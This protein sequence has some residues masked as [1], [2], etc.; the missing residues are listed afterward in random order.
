MA[1]VPTSVESDPEYL[2]STDTEPTSQKTRA[3]VV[4][5]PNASQDPTLLQ[6][7]GYATR[8]PSPGQTESC[9]EGERNTS[10]LQKAI[11]FPLAKRK[12]LL[13][14]KKEVD[15]GIIARFNEVIPEIER[16]LLSHIRSNRFFSSST[17]H[18]PMAIRLMVLG[19]TESDAEECMV[20]FCS[21]DLL[22]RVEQFFKKDPIVRDLCTPRDN[23]VP[24]FKVIVNAQPP[25]P[26]ATF[27]DI[28]VHCASSLSTDDTFCGTPIKFVNNTEE[29]RIATFCGIIKVTSS[30]GV[31]KLYGMTAGH[32]LL[33]WEY[34][35]TETDHFVSGST[36][37]TSLDGENE[38]GVERPG[39][40]VEDLME[41]GDSFVQVSAIPLHTEQ[42]ETAEAWLF[43]ESQ[44][45]GRVLQTSNCEAGVEDEGKQYFDWALFEL[46]TYRQNEL[47]MAELS[48][49]VRK[50]QLSLA[51]EKLSPDSPS[52]LV[53]VMG[54]SQG[55][56]RGVLSKL[57]G[58][59]IMGPGDA[60]INAYLLTLD[61]GQS[62][63]ISTLD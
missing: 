46:N 21:A 35:E 18:K 43:P 39:D 12:E 5:E 8:W 19:K 24:S 56:K 2:Q 50:H 1:V 54:G 30:N 37:H 58:R 40:S 62:K 22:K 60:F 33:D 47:R 31:F 13:V 7:S 48:G 45:L 3:H 10:I 59:I 23:T 44:E 14:F 34:P 57:P 27:S 25:R 20:V 61:D 4:S 36:I 9:T 11:P 16:L 26:R 49:N 55:P 63:L 17:R 52:Q 15:R 29:F 51:S 32:T 28:Q 38:A 6:D 53:T 41:L 42:D